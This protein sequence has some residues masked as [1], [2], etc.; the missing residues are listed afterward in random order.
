MTKIGTSPDMWISDNNCAD[1]DSNRMKRIRMQISKSND[2]I[3]RMQILQITISAYTTL[4][5]IYT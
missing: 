4:A 1:L 2:F 3:M 5:I